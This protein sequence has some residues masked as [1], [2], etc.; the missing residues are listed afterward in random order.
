MIKNMKKRCNGVKIKN[1]QLQEWKVSKLWTFTLDDIQSI[2]NKPFTV[3]SMYT[4]ILRKKVR[5]KHNF[6]YIVIGLYA[7]H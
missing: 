1:E 5:I 3:L 6:F 7:Q 4:S 2:I